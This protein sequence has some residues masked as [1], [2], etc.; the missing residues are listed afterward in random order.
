MA[1][2][3]ISSELLTAVSRNIMA[4]CNAQVE[5]DAGN[6][7][8]NIA[9]DPYDPRILQALFGEQWR[10]MVECPS[11]WFY[12]RD[13]I[14]VRIEVKSEQGAFIKYCRPDFIS[15]KPNVSFRVP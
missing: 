12:P 6:E 9:I 2:V 5:R 14:D 8:G 4:M 1:T 7:P 15:S 11:D 10:K 13:D 3:R